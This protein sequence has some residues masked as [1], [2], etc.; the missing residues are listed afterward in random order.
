[1]CIRDSND[2]ITRLITSDVLWMMVGDTKSAETISTSKLFEYFGS[3]K[4][5]LGC[6]PDGAAKTALEEYR[7]SFITPPD[8]IEAIYNMLIKINDL[9]KRKMLP[10]PNEEFVEK[11]NR[12][13]LTEQL[14]KQFQFFLKEE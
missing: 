3:K 4:P 9:Y 14:V 1:M 10:S 13:I 8:D 2:S 11:H 5:V 12:V 7:A 6:V